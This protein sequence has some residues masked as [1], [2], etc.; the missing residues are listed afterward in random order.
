MGILTISP[1][2]YEGLMWFAL[3]LMLLAFLPL[4]HNFY[5]PYGKY[6]A[7]IPMQNSKIQGLG[8]LVF[9]LSLYCACSMLPCGRYYYEPE[10]GYVGNPWVKFSYQ[11]CYVYLMWLVHHLDALEHSFYQYYRHRSVLGLGRRRGI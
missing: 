3:W 1:T 8:F 7:I 10:G 4:L 5:N 2:H 9:M 6:L 11:Y